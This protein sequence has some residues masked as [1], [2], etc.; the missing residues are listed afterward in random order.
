MYTL[1]VV[2]GKGCVIVEFEG[3]LSEIIHTRCLTVG[4]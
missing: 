4:N 1:C 3:I 2:S